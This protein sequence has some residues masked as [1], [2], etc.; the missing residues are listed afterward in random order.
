MCFYDVDQQDTNKVTLTQF[1]INFL[2]RI[3]KSLKLP[4]QMVSFRCSLIMVK[5]SCQKS[6]II[7]IIITIM[8]K[9]VIATSPC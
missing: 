6:K 3:I 9:R 2:A 5:G 8:V 1:I 4:W 7:I